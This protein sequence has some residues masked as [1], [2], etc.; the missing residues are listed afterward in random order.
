MRYIFY[1]ITKKE[2]RKMRVFCFK[3]IYLAILLGILTSPQVLAKED[4]NVK[5]LYKQQDEILL[6]GRVSDKEGPLAGVNVKIEGTKKGVVTDAEGTFTITAK[7]NQ[8]LI[9][10]YL[11]YISQKIP[12]SNKTQFDIT[13]V[14]D[15]AALDEVIVVGYGTQKK[16]NLTGAVGTVSSEELISRQ[17]PNTTSLLQGRVPGAQI[18]QNSGQPGAESANIQIRGMGTFRTGGGSKQTEKGGF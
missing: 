4:V 10:S 14:S 11:G 12:I 15:A 2:N 18:T 3:G 16:A 5:N 7:S 1:Q 8:H 9:V 6:K 13:L 17:A